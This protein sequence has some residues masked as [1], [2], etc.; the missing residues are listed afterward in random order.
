MADTTTTNFALVKPEVGSSDDTWGGKLNTNLDTID[1]HLVPIGA[2]LMWSGSIASI[3]ATWALCDGTSGTP[4]LRDRF[5]VGAGSTYVVAA[6]G[7]AATVTLT[8][9]E[10]AAHD[11]FFTA[12]T[13]GGEHSHVI[14][15]IFPSVLNHNNGTGTAL[16]S[17]GA[18]GTA[19]SSSSI[20]E[21][22][23][24]HMHTI[25]GDTTSAGGGT[26]HENRPP[27]Y[28]LAYIMKLA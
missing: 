11:H 25:S 3:P 14:E 26:A 10:L 5:I 28:A 4:D 27:Y 8:E 6:T 19:A 15:D 20:S 13:V 2:I 24:E 1:R 21:L 12:I 7:G 16:S 18:A 23:G 22:A 17:N 9:A